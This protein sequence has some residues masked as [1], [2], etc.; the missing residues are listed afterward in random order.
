MQRASLEALKPGGSRPGNPAC[1]ALPPC[2]RYPPARQSSCASPLPLPHLSCLVKGLLGLGAL[3]SPPPWL[4]RRLPL[5]LPLRAAP[6]EEAR[7]LLGAGASS[8]LP[9]SSSSSS[10]SSS[11]PPTTSAAGARAWDRA[12]VG[13]RAGPLRCSASGAGRGAW[14]CTLCRPAPTL[15]SP[16][17]SSPRPLF[18]HQLT[19][20]LAVLGQQL[21]QLEHG[22]L[23]AREQR[24]ELVVC[25]GEVLRG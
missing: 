18:P 20:G 21:L 14:H 1:P 13:A 25:K 7:R 15:S 19:A 24:L 8:P 10:S 11:L 9:A 2:R 12:R 17:A 16:A 6:P 5:L 23:G 22:G 4:L 3:P